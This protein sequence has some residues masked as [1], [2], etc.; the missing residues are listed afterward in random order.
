MPQGVWIRLARSIAGKRSHCCDARSAWADFCRMSCVQGGFG[1]A[2][3]PMTSPKYTLSNSRDIIYF[4]KTQPLVFLL[5]ISDQTI[6]VHACYVP[7]HAIES[8]VSKLAAVTY[9]Y[10][11]RI[12][13]CACAC[14]CAGFLPSLR[15]FYHVRHH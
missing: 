12:R 3:W 5:T 7:C 13:I 11:L 6:I 4:A 1:L 15:L 8:Y 10:M 2:L 9:V 14:I